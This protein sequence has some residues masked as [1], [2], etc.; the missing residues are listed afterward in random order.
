GYLKHVYQVFEKMGF[1]FGDKNSDW[2][3][4][5]SHDYPFVTYKSVMQNLKPY[6]KIN[7]FPGSGYITNKVYLAQ[8]NM[9]FIPLAF[10][11]PAQK[12]S[13]VN[14]ASS[15]TNTSWVQKSNNHRGI[16]VKKFGDVD[17]TK[18][19]TFVQQFIGNPFLID[20]R[21]FDIGVYMVIA[22]IDPL[23]AYVID[24]ETLF[25]FCPQEY[26]PFDSNNLDKYVIGDDYLP[27]W[28]LPSLEKYILTHGFSFKN[29]FNNFLITMGH[30][31]KALWDKIYF[32]IRE[33]LLQKESE[34]VSSLQKYQSKRNFFEMMRFDF[35]V[36]DHMQVFLMEANM[37]PNLSSDHFPDNARLY[38]HVIFNYL[39]LV[40]VGH[41][42]SSSNKT[43][44]SHDDPMYVSSQDI[45]VFPEYCLGK[46][47][48]ANCHPLVC[49]LCK[50][51]LTSDLSNAIKTAYLEHNR[52]GS[53]RRIFPP[54]ISP[55]DALKW[56]PKSDLIP[57]DKLNWK[58]KVMYIWFIGKCKQDITWCS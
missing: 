33:V 43:S 4:M 54:P 26:Y 21:M 47:C 24:G 19:D 37:S 5:W 29:S 45:H 20:G 50:Q 32:A 38:E 16:Q 52:R 28:K 44:F 41:L 3:V 18:G 12:S 15:N 53:A 8:T 25:R 2:L 22:S 14:F 9:H 39:G 36:D 30:E 46:A 1:K 31:P 48:T 56:T 34:L 51:C 13:F 49:K 40:G 17:L 7:H 23:R 57:M 55:S 27:M 11:L 58:N 42:T 35:L 6:Q 10:A